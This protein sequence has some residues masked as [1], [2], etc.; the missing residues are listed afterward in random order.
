MIRVLNS[1]LNHFFISLHAIFFSEFAHEAVFVRLGKSVNSL[2]FGADIDSLRVDLGLGI[3]L[4]I[5]NFA[6]GIA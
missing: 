6:I 4:N 5:L 2:I 3:I 1:C